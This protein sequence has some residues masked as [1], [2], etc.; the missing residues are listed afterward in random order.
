MDRISRQ[1][2]PAAAR[3]RILMAA[4][5]EFAGRGYAGARV[6]RLA[7]TARVNKRMLYHYFG[8]KQGLYRAVLDDRLPP[9][10]D[11]A[12]GAYLEPL[13]ARLLL[14]TLLEPAAADLA[15]QWRWNR[16]MLAAVLA[17]LVPEGGIMPRKPRIRL[18]S[19][20]GD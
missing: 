5:V 20:A 4:A 14:W 15:G 13:A 11:V 10:A 9:P 7:A 6:D 1:R 18:A 3:R 8:D 17:A 12:A 19:R 16:E 2:D